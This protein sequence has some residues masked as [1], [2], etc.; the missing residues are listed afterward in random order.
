VKKYGTA[1]EVTD[2]NAV[3]CMRFACWI[4]KSTDIHSE[5]VILTA[6]PRQQ[7]LRE[8]T[9][10]LLYSKLPFLFPLNVS[11]NMNRS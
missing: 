1:R 7:M 2:N 11:F 9:S 5:Y 10:L 6:F 3:Q 8:R 4:I